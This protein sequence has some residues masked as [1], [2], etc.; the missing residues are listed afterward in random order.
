M[1]YVTELF[2]QDYMRL[3]ASFP[4]T[5]PKQFGW[6]AALNML[7]MWYINWFAFGYPAHADA[8]AV[9]VW[10]GCIMTVFFMGLK[11]FCLMRTCEKVSHGVPFILS[12]IQFTSNRVFWRDTTLLEYSWRSQNAWTQSHMMRPKETRAGYMIESCCGSAV[13]SSYTPFPRSCVKMYNS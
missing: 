7:W 5:C 13:S 3:S 10:A 6:R 2:V 1:G 12:C 8:P 11:S 9:H 4:P